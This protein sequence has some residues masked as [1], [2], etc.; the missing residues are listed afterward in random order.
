MVAM[1]NVDSLLPISYPVK[2]AD[3][4]KTMTALMTVMG[5]FVM[6]FIISFLV[7]FRLGLAF[8]SLW[9]PT[10]TTSYGKFMSLSVMR[11]SDGGN[12]SNGIADTANHTGRDFIA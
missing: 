3:T 6:F 5:F 11:G 8:E 9:P 4:I 2:P 12:I 1:G 10:E 7:D